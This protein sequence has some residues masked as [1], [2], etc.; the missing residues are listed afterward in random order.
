MKKRETLFFRRI[1]QCTVFALASLFPAFSYAADASLCAEVKIEV[2]QE[3]TLERQAFD[4]HMRI[5]NGLSHITLENVDVDVSFADEDGNSVLASSDPDDPDALFFIRIDS[6]ENIDDVDGA[7][8]IAPSSS[9]DIHWLIIPSPGA[10]NGVPQGTLYYVGAT[11]TYTIAGEEH[12]TVVTPDYIFVKPMPELTLDYF[13]PTDVYGDDAFTPEIEPPVP[14]SLGV[15]AKNSGLGVAREMKISSG[16]PKI[17]ENEQ[18]LLIGF[19]IEGC[20][21]NGQ[22]AT[23]SLLADLGDIEPNASAV[24]RWTMTC[25]LSGQFVEFTADYSHSDELG[26]ELTSLL[27]AVNT[28]VLVRDVLVDV[29]GRDSIRDFLAKEGAGYRVFESENTDTDVE[30]LSASSS[31]NGSGDNYTLL[32]PVTAGFMY[33][34]LPDPFSGQKDIKQVVRSD[35]KIIKPENAWLSKTRNGQAWDYYFNIFD[36]NATGSY[37]VT[38]EDAAAQNH[39]PVL[40][41]IANRSVVE[42]EQVSFLVQATDP[43]G[44]IPSL[45]ATPLPALA[46]FTDQGDGTGVFD[47]TPAEGQAGQYEVTFTAS[48]GILDDSQLVVL[49]VNT[50]DDT[51]GDGMPD[52]WEI[53]HF[54][55]L[56]RDGTGDFDGDGISDLDEFLNGTD[57][58]HCNNAPTVPVIQTP[59]IGTEVASLTPELVIQNSTDP[60]GDTITY[61]FELY[62][63]EEMTNW[64]GMASGVSEGVETTSWTLPSP[65]TDNARYFW[66]V[67]A[68]DGASFSLWAYGSFFVNTENDPPG[69]FNISAPVDGLEVDTLTP[70]LQVTNSVDV[71]EDAV[72]YTFEVYADSDMSGL[73]TSASGIPQG[74]DGTTSWAVNASLS[75]N[76]WYYWKAVAID[77]HGAAVETAQGSFMVNTLNAAPCIP[78][79]SSPAAGSEVASQEPDLVVTNATDPD[80]DAVSYFF[81]LDKVDTF[82]SGEKQ[83]SGAVSEGVDSTLWHVSALEDNTLYYWRVKAAD[84]SAESGWVQG[85][86]FVNTANDA[87]AIPTLRN[88]GE[89]AWVDTPRPML[90]LNPT[91]DPDNDGLTCRFE[92]YAD[93]VLSSL[94][95]QGETDIREWTLP[96]ALNDSTWYYWRARAKDEHGLA[97][98]WT[99]A[100]PFFV[101]DNG[102]DDPPDITILEP[103]QD[104]LTNGQSLLIRWEDSDPDSN[105]SISL[106]YD[107]DDAG[108]DG[109]LITSDLSEDEDGD[110]DSYVWDIT[111]IQDGTYYV[112]ASITDGTTAATNYSPGRVTL[113]RTPPVVEAT[114]PAGTYTAAQE[115]TLSANEP[116]DIYYTTNGTDPT[117]GSSAY[118]SPITVSED[119]TLKFMAVDTAGNQ[120]GVVT[121]GYTI[122]QDI[123]V[124]VTTDKGRRLSG[125]RVYAFTGTGSYTGKYATTNGDGIGLFN[126][127]DFADGDYKFRA[128]YLGNQFWSQTITLPDTS[129]IEVTIEEETVEVVVTTNN[130]SAQG[131]KVYLFSE[132]GSYLGL[133]EITDAEG[134]VSFVLPVGRGFKF[135]ADILG[136]Q[137]WSDVISVTGGGVNNVPVDAGGGLFQVSVEKDP[138]IPMQGIKVYLFSQSGSYLGRYQVT[139][140]SGLVGFDVSGGTYKVRADYLGYQFWSA[141]TPV[142]ED[143]NIDLTI[144]HQ[145][146]E[147]TV[148]TVFQADSD[149]IEGTKVYLFKPSGSYLGQYQVTDENGQVFFDLPEMAYKVRADYLG[150]QFWSGDFIWQDVEVNVPMADA[151]VTVTGAGFPREGVKVYLFSASGSYLGL[152]ETTNDQGK[153][154][155]RIPESTYRFRADYQG[156]Q[157][158]S[159]DTALAADQVN[160]INISTGGGAFT[161]MVL[162]GATEPLVGINCYVFSEEGSYLGMHG[163][164]NGDGEVGFDLS[165]GV[166]KFRVDYFGYQFWSEV[167]TIPDASSV[168]VIIEQEQVEVAVETGS[169]PA[170]SVK[171]HLFSEAGS[172][173]GLYEVTDTEGKV[174]FDLPVGRGFKFRADI[175][176]NQYWSDVITVAG[177]GVNNVP[178]DAGGGLFQVT[179]EKG[180]DNPMEGIKVYLFNDSGTYLGLYQVTDAAGVVVFSVPQGTYK[181]RADYSGYQ[182]WSPDTLVN[183][184]TDIVLALTHQQVEV[185]V[186]GLFQGATDPIEGIKVYLFP[187]SGSYLGLYEVTDS[188]GKVSFDLPGKSYK[189]RADYMQQQYWSQPFTWQDVTVEVP[190]ADAEITVTG[191]GFPQDGVKVYVFTAA[192]SYLG[193]YNTTDSAGKVS[194]RVPEGVYKFRVDYQGSQFWSAE[195]ALAKDQM[196]PILI[197]VGGGAFTLTIIKGA[198]EPLVGVKCY[199]FNEGGT[200][201]GMFGATN[202][203]GDVAF[204]LADGTYKFRIDHLGYQFWS[205]LVIV[206]GTVELTETIAHQ[207]VTIIVEGVLG[208][209]TEARSGIKV[210]LFQPSGSYLGQYQVTDADGHVSFD[211]PG[212]AYKVRTDYL[213]QQFWSE[214]FTWQDSTV[215]IPEGTARVHVTMAGQDL[216]G[217]KVYVFSAGDAYLGVYETTDPDGIALFRLPAGTYRFRSDHQTNQ[218]WATGEILA[219]VVNNI[220]I[221][222]GGG[223]FVFTIDTGLDP[224]IGTRVYVFNEAGAYL[225]LYDN[226]NENGEV[227]F[228]LSDGSYKFRVDHLGYQF[229]SDMFQVPDSLSGSLTIMHQDVVISV[230]GFYQ[231]AEPLNGLKVY[232]FTPAGSYLGQ[233]Q[234]TD[235][236]GHVTFDLPDQAYKVRADYLG[237]QFWSADFQSQ[238]TTVTIQEGLARVHVHRSGAD[239]EGARVYLF[240]EGGSYLGWYEDTNASGM[241]EFVLPDRPYKFRVDE[242]G[243]QHWTPV[244]NIIAGQVNTIDVALD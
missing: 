92:V 150:Q 179:V 183:A 72:T 100:A 209:D 49:R 22:P 10:A 148:S 101:R 218:Y 36:A 64:V 14:F 178:I 197:S 74:T 54:G 227:R 8:S 195:A 164:T 65:L 147:V 1:A 143:T 238:A 45:A 228:S 73:V 221:D 194:F 131:V 177:G 3:L 102:V 181:V 241:A 192:G 88:P 117:S 56:D 171:V 57:P 174:S 11:L 223:E 159:P 136:N 224:L 126:P 59:E 206:P 91:M 81:E 214:E 121:S 40:Q 39:A 89:N 41:F 60:D 51:D 95:A 204:D 20:E 137:Y 17:V 186:A 161:V 216:E 42:G 53:E 98:D 222:T 44:T 66:R 170:E 15:R 34:K 46:A 198:A 165:D 173:L 16:L 97:G 160:Y 167:V 244:C 112:Y 189:V 176:G 6:M 127:D 113:D 180:T 109:E 21:V 4:A 226:S 2:K 107:T 43:D 152:Y 196:N 193:L 68:A 31:L 93:E 103:A 135:R 162:K 77:E 108:Q 37:T 210:Y 25:S 67:R 219:D 70:L 50:S 232:L 229:W 211:L 83:S 172:Y 142:F 138:D 7:G 231:E 48:D 111:G 239:V 217:V 242:G 110:A 35:G 207:E 115:V 9:A 27:S 75:D 166:Y 114:P 78:A 62:S 230:E 55:T 149:P 205:Q 156:S 236:D 215:S 125:L 191:A 240:S 220:E 90:R 169:G 38:F 32:I 133:Y 200:Y 58:T 212:Q 185:T 132:S 29:S 106:Y 124:T 18:G 202:S 153:V 208:E 84:G 237:Q 146:V 69:S 19:V 157:F 128:D 23:K 145:Q 80:G 129:A 116:A 79:I 52:A 140:S 47:W 130:G 201:L 139:G 119:T 33:V 134:K 76:T 87:P 61:V 187:E 120:S 190:M 175:L 203:N 86:F 30:D 71:D 141:D 94:T 12:V 234:V 155:F 163:S 243:Y 233:Y 118:A 82:D 5:N 199:V 213:G 99:D 154:S 96:S 63:D 26:G 188:E 104:I 85:S 158:W 182:F 225:G 24:A 28:H 184:D 105:A 151:E 13:L 144:A 168:E 123:T 122:Q 235:S